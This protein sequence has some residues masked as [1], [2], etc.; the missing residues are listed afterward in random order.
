MTH[1]RFS[2]ILIG[3]CITCGEMLLISRRKVENF[4]L[5]R[6]EL[7]RSDPKNITSST[8]QNHVCACVNVAVAVRSLLRR[9]GRDRLSQQF[10]S[11][12]DML[13]ILGKYIIYKKIGYGHQVSLGTMGPGKNDLFNMFTHF[14]THQ[15]ISASKIEWL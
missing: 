4:L 9:Y 8:S 11:F 5:L 7:R 14:T 15:F 10:F 13:Q 6:R 1:F 12:S 3:C 2:R